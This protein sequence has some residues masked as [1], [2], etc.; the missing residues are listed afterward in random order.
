MDKASPTR[1]AAFVLTAMKEGRSQE[2][3]SFKF[4]AIAQD[5]MGNS[6][7]SLPLILKNEEYSDFSHTPHPT[8]F[9][10][11]SGFSHTPHPFHRTA[12][13]FRSKIIIKPLLGLINSQ[14]LSPVFD[15]SMTKCPGIAFW[16]IRVLQ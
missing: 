3:I 6:A 16:R 10:R 5:I 8:P 4:S 13:L 12:F 14:G 9:H 11:Y 2:S 15:H 7:Q 1:I